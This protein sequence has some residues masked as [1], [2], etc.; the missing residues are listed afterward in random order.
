M[1]TNKITKT[2]WN[3]V[4]KMKVPTITQQRKALKSTSVRKHVTSILRKSGETRFQAKKKKLFKIAYG[5]KVS[6]T[7]LGVCGP[8]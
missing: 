7:I 4:N 3:E 5:K 6:H 2:N 1:G 8:L